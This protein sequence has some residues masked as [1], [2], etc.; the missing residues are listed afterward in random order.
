[1]D[2]SEINEDKKGEAMEVRHSIRTLSCDDS[3]EKHEFSWFF[4]GFIW[5][6]V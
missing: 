1:M 2:Q 6:A 4:I 5:M 3:M